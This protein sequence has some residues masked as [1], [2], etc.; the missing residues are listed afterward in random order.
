MKIVVVQEYAL[1]PTASEVIML[2]SI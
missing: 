1:R 2:L